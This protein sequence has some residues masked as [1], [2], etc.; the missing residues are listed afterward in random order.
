MASGLAILVLLASIAFS[1][2]NAAGRNSAAGGTQ[3]LPSST[4]AVGIRQAFNEF[5]HPQDST[6]TKV[7]WFHGET[8]TTR[9][10]ITADLEAFKEAGVGGVVYYDQVHGNG[11]GAFDAMSREWWDMLKF[12]AKEAKRLGLSFEINISNGYVAGGP[13][14]TKD[15]GMQQVCSSETFARGPMHL[16]ADLPA[17]SKDS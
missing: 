2:Q 9:E 12:A 5:Q 10:G 8:R 6:R 7:W 17:P 11:A 16:D 14:I 15:M 4:A 3:H 13:W 1:G